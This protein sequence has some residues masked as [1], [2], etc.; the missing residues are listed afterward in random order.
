MTMIAV[1]S[2]LDA[3]MTPDWDWHRKAAFGIR[4]GRASDGNGG[5]FLPAGC[6]LRQQS[7]PG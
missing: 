7:N 5:A 2:K 1:L 6:I 3:M 4:H